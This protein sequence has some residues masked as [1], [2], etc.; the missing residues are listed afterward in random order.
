MKIKVG[1]DTLSTFSIVLSNK[2]GE[3]LIAGYD[4]ASNSFYISR[5]LSGKVD[6]K[7]GFAKKQL[8][9]RLAV[10]KNAD[11]TFIFDAASV[12][13]FADGG[14]T[15]MTDI[16]FPTEP[17]SFIQLQAPRPLPLR[18]IQINTLKGIWDK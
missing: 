3:K 10:S 6:F 5:M 11:I 18:L 1:M 14:L 2:K 7:N 8:A 17:Y 16:F 4:K 12:E 13:L 15:V 9:P